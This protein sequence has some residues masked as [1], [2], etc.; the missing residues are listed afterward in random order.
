MKLQER[1][2]NMKKLDWFSDAVTGGLNSVGISQDIRNQAQPVIDQAKNL[3]PKA[4]I[5]PA[6][7]GIFSYPQA[8][9]YK[10]SGNISPVMIAAAIGGIII[11]A[12]VAKGK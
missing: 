9:G 5:A 7:T 10:Y 11:I 2:E 4:G 12:Y 3:L 8:T 6:T 1:L